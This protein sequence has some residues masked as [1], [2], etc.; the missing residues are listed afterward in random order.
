MNG[1]N[2]CL[3]L[4]LIAIAAAKPAP[5]AASV[6]QLLDVQGKAQIRQGQQPPQAGALLS[7]LRAGDTV[8]VH[9]GRA[10]LVLFQT[11]GHGTPVRMTDWRETLNWL[12]AR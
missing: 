11:G 1:R 10:E 3:I 5:P 9:T 4:P 7:P 2:L 12:L 6:G 8:K